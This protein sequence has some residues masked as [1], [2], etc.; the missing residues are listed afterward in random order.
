MDAQQRHFTDQEA[1]H[2]A[3]AS[4]PQLNDLLPILKHI[5]LNNIKNFIDKEINKLDETSSKR[6]R[7]NAFSINEIFFDDI[8]QY[9]LSFVGIYHTKSVNKKWKKLSDK[10]EN[11]YLKQLYEPIINTIT[12]SPILYDKNIN[13]T[14]IIH[15]YRKTLHN[16]E[17]DLGFHGIIHSIDDAI[18]MCNS[19]DALLLHNGLYTRDWI[20]IKKNIHIIGVGSEVIIKDEGSGDSFCIMGSWSN[21]RNPFSID[22]YFENLKFNCVNSDCTEG[23]IHLSTGCKLWVNGCKFIFDVTTGLQCRN[24]A[25]LNVNNCEFIGGTT[26]IEISPISKE[27]NI[28]NSVFNGCGIESDFC[29]EG[30]TACVLV[31]EDSYGDLHGSV[32]DYRNKFVYLKC[33]GNIF[34]NNMCMTIAE[35]HVPYDE[36]GD[37]LEHANDEFIINT[38]RCI[39]R[40]NVLKGQNGI[41]V[42]KDIEINDA[43]KMYYNDVPTKGSD[44]Q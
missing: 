36:L 20:W 35:R 4:A 37:P 22:V 5:S 2:D 21:M 33:I 41:S 23:I 43:N 40:N 11:I 39:L 25:T 28:I 29:Y 1:L 34:E 30:E 44:M 38:D 31:S 6:M 27:V 18:E 9:I 12:N 24:D 32:E 19:G 8:I 26:A 42:R 17:T 16:V 7:F 15:P 14:Y 3:V 13:S 10:N